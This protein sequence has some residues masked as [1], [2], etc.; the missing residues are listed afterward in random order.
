VVEILSRHGRRYDEVVK[1]HLY[2]RGGVPEY[3]IVDPELETVKVYRRGED[4]GFGL[5][6]E[7]A[8]ERGERLES[9]LLPGLSLPLVE[10]FA[11]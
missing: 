7:L 8:A 3:W 11:S 6:T 10:L 5:A 2:D 4:G 9:P 1:R